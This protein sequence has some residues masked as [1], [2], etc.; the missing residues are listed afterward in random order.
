MSVST[1]EDRMSLDNTAEDP[2]RRA[3]LIIGGNDFTSITDKVCSIVE[4]PKPPKG[5]HVEPED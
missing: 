5:W 1:V 3:P 4:R 2:R